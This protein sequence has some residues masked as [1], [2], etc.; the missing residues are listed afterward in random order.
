MDP[1]SLKHFAQNADIEIKKLTKEEIVFDLIGAEPPLAN[2]LRRI[3]IAEIPTVAIEKV[4]M[5][6][7]TS[8]IPDENLAHRVGLIPLEADGRDFDYHK[9]GEEYTPKNSIKFKLHKICTKKDPSAP[10]VLNNTHDEEQLYNNA[11]IYS[12]DLEFVA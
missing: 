11:N 10:V 5:W 12:G 3:M 6:Q 4:T 9:E 1:S 7:N 8:I 2:A